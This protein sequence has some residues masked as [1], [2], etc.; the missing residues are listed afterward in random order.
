[1]KV[2]DLGKVS[3][4]SSLIEGLG[5]TVIDARKA[6]ETTR[7]NKAMENIYTERLALDEKTLE[8]RE[9]ERKTREKA[10]ENAMT[11]RLADQEL[12]KREQ[13]LQ[14]IRKT[15][16]MF[17]QWWNSMDAQQQSIAKTSEQY[18][19]MQKFFKVFK[20]LVP[21]MVKDDGTI[22]A[23]TPKDM[24][25]EKLEDAQAAAKMRL[26]QGTGTPQDIQLL[27]ITEA[28]KDAMSGILAKLEKEL[29]PQEKKNPG[30]FTQRFSD[31]WA[32]FKGKKPTS[33]ALS[34]PVQATPQG[35]V[36][37]N[38]IQPPAGGSS[39]PNSDPLG[40]LGR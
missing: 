35:A 16:E 24:A 34:Q 33:D 4:R 31:A 20:A 13:D 23:S 6:S 1:M 17:S 40:I 12:R 3:R 19:E 21:G 25:K 2:V 38:P 29:T 9:K 18:K 27:K 28:D 15:H 11:S 39:N 10:E 7:S 5:D 22:V 30:T 8:I 32:A 26:A 37:T 36:P 14:N